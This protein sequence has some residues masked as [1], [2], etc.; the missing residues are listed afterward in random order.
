MITQHIRLKLTSWFVLVIMFVSALLS[1][2]LF[3]AV[4][5]ELRLDYLR[6]E[7]RIQNQQQQ[8]IIN[9]GSMP[10]RMLNQMLPGL[11]DEIEQLE[12][13]QDELNSFR[14][15][16]LRRLIWFNL[17]VFVSSALAGYWLAGRSIQP[18]VA[19][20]ERERNFSSHVSH[21][22]R[23]P[24]SALQT[25]LEVALADKQAGVRQKKVIKESL[26]EVRHLDKL[27]NQLLKLAKN[28]EFSLQEINTQSSISDLLRRA[29]KQ[30]A[31]SAKKSGHKIQWQAK[32]IKGQIRGELSIWLEVLGAIVENALKFSPQNKPVLITIEK[33]AKFWQ[34]SVVDQGPGVS[35]AERERIFQHFY[36]S[37][38]ARTR[39]NNSGLGVGLSLARRLARS[40]G[41]DVQLAKS[42]DQGSRFVIF[43]PLV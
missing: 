39:G 6:A 30:F 41:G 24:I 9:P 3:R 11:N 32:N 5:A 16:F 13:F 40:L 34:I 28:G 22:L 35:K 2:W 26:E 36:K 43:L 38:Y 1:S 15:D 29:K 14:Q 8:Q 17:L 19:A 4:E 18:L 27:V 12:L 31:L 42:N 33:S 23:T 37:D 21:E 10:R 7:R 20:L 25:T